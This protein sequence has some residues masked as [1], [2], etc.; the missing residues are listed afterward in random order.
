MSL[1]SAEFTALA[2]R[3]NSTCQSAIT[4]L[5]IHRELTDRN[6]KLPTVDLLFTRSVDHTWDEYFSGLDAC[7]KTFV[8]WLS[9]SQVERA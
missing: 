7:T 5:S 9:Q 3:W 8:S 1:V 6:V 2:D 4:A